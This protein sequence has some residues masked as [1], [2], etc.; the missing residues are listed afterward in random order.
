M[1]I[2]VDTNVL[3]RS[4]TLSA[5]HIAA[6]LAVA[7]TID[8]TAVLP[9]LVLEESVSARRRDAM[10]AFEA[11]SAA[12]K[13]ASRY[14]DT[15]TTYI[16]SAQ[17]VADD[18]RESLTVH[19]EVISTTPEIAVEALEREAHRRRPARGGSGGRDAAI[20]LT[21]RQD[22]ASR[23]A[24]S[25]FLTE[26]TSD[27]S[28]PLNKASLHPELLEDCGSMQG[29]L[30]FYPSVDDFL[31][32]VAPTLDISATPDQLTSSSEFILALKRTVDT[33]ILP[34]L[35]VRRAESRAQVGVDVYATQPI[36]ITALRPRSL[37]A[38][39]VSGTGYVLLFFDAELT[40]SIGVLTRGKAA[41]LEIVFPL[42]LGLRGRG[43]LALASDMNAVDNVE[44]PY[45]D[46]VTANS[47][48]PEYEVFYPARQ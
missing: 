30:A 15:V 2:Y 47:D 26:N 25:Y 6:L 28:D 9:S 1:A 16:P 14:S 36:E 37:R 38:Y 43:W 32:A 31:A 34:R 33:E 48:D 18:W 8:Q 19:F 29:K 23:D 4:G 42:R 12:H 41:A 3:P 44:V 10:V 46:R 7:N 45:L 13:R 22:A 11:L 24:V 40:T 20:W 21:V 35:V 17:D 27:F 5:P 39:D